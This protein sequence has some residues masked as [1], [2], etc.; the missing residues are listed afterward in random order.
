MQKYPNGEHIAEMRVQLAGLLQQQNK[1]VEAAELYSQVKGDPEFTFTAKFKAAECYYAELQGASAKDNKGPKIDTESVRKLALQN[2]NEAIKMGPEAERTA[3]GA[4]KTA[5]HEIRGEAAYMLASILE[6]DPE[7]VDY[8]QVATL[9]TGYES[10]YPKLSAK[11][12]D[13]AEWRITALDHLGRY[14]EVNSDVAAIVDTQ[15]RQHRQ[16]RLHQGT[17]NRFLEGRAGSQG[18]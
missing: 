11:F 6:E 12:Q 7:K 3:S 9:L 4:G 14:D 2:L 5:V 8:A 1:Y 17:W 10:E 13:V 15:S 16:G 18:Q